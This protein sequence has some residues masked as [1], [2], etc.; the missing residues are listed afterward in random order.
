LLILFALLLTVNGATADPDFTAIPEGIVVGRQALTP[1]LDGVI[2][3]AEWDPFFPGSTGYLQWDYEALYAAGSAPIGK[4][5]V[6]SLDC[7]GNG[8]LVGADNL[9]FVATFDGTN[10]TVTVKL[11][12]ATNVAGPQWKDAN[13]IQT[14]L[15]FKASG[16]ASDWTV[17]IRI[18]ATNPYGL[19]LK[20]NKRLAARFD[21]VE[22]TEFQPFSPR[23]CAP[24]ML[25]LDK[26][27]DIPAGLVWKSNFKARRMDAGSD[28]NLG[29]ELKN[30]AGDAIDLKRVKFT[31]GGTTDKWVDTVERALEPL[32]AGQ[33]TTTSYSTKVNDNITPGFHAIDVT[34]ELADGRT[35]HATSSFEI[36]PLLTFEWGIPEVVNSEATDWTIISWVR[37]RNNTPAKMS[38][39]FDLVLPEG[40]KAKRGPGTRFSLMGRADKARIG[41]EFL[42]PAG[43]SGVQRI[44]AVAKFS[45]GDI[46]GHRWIQVKATKQ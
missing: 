14:A 24:A 36:L 20:E 37:I 27:A 32:A 39:T 2:S 40:W 46:T 1:K 15:I 30:S 41:I 44:E 8:W 6:V 26:G 16:A 31:G 9:Q 18:P 4:A 10:A 13:L 19:E 23:A 21:V 33:K 34:G 12:D 3:P 17:E 43:T 7:E 38:G 28:L 25:V 5:I 45:S 42:V 22:G 35:F 29:F 11:L